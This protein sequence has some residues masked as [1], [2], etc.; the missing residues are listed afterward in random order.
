MGVEGIYHRNAIVSWE[1][2]ANGEVHNVHVRD[3]KKEKEAIE[4]MQKGAKNA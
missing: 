1:V 4:K 2:K 3:Y